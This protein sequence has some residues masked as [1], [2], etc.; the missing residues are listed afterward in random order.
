MHE[1]I[2]T[3]N[4]LGYDIPLTC[5]DDNIARTR[6]MGAY[7]AST[8]L[9]YA[10]GLPLETESLFLEPWRQARAAGVDTPRLA[11]LCQILVQLEL[12]KP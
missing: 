2:H 12:L 11:A 7:Y 1:V 10:R 9:D 3:A 6:S 8:L 4:Q 5:A